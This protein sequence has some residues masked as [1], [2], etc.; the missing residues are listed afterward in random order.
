MCS[1]R[2]LRW[3]LDQSGI[4]S[5]TWRLRVRKLPSDGLVFLR[6]CGRNSKR[7]LACSL[8]TEHSVQVLLPRLAVWSNAYSVESRPRVAA[9]FVL[10]CVRADP[11]FV[12]APMSIETDE[13]IVEPLE[14]NYIQSRE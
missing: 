9:H 2:T 6:S 3:L 5:R 13:F 12:R 11:P 8:K 10:L 7:K 1:R 4:G 14:W